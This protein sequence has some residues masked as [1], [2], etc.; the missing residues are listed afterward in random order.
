VTW[1]RAHWLIVA[2][3]ALAAA[4]IAYR[5][6]GGLSVVEAGHTSPEDAVAAG[7]MVYRAG[8]IGWVE[9]SPDG[10]TRYDHGSGWTSDPFAATADSLR[11][12]P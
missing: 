4:W 5:V 2:A 10:Q 11:D 1:L 7:W 8:I 9:I 6:S 3:L 12:R